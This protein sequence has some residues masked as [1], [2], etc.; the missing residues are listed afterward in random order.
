MI[1]P[2][3]HLRHRYEAAAAA[4]VAVDLSEDVSTVWSTSGRVVSEPS[5]VAIQD[6]RS[7]V[8]FGFE[9]DRAAAISDNVSTLSPIAEGLWDNAIVVPF[10]K[11]LLDRGGVTHLDH[12]PVFLPV[13]AGIPQGI[14]DSWC[15]AVR[16]TGGNPLLV[17]R[18]LAAAIALDVRSSG[19]RCHLVIETTLEHVEAVAISEGVVVDSRQFVSHHG[20]DLRRGIDRMLWQLDP[21]DEFEIRDTGIYIHG[22]A[23]RREW[24]EVV[25]S[26]GIP[27]A[28]PLGSGL[29]VIEGLCSMAEEILPWLV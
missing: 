4:M 24:P 21:D 28:A 13:S 14:R 1:L 10:L 7:L 23:A 2:R 8:G 11:W 9:A 5:R 15:D 16:A 27:L 17:D 19:S 25:D 22:W 12:V 29:T 20:T 18:A 3:L 26:V 6:G